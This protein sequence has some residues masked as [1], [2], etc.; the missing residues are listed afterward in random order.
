MPKYAVK[1]TLL[2][3]FLVCRYL[4]FHFQTAS[5][6]LNLSGATVNFFI[7]S[8]HIDHLSQSFFPPIF[9][10]GLSQFN[11]N[12]GVPGF[13][14]QQCDFDSCDYCKNAQLGMFLIYLPLNFKSLQ[15]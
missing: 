3:K 7:L 4:Q 11:K 8:I 1:L 9:R 10:R 6:C 5:L 14:C 12:A 15:L 2:S 13:R